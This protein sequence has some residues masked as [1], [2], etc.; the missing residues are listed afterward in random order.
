MSNKF[1]VFLLALSVL[2]SQSFSRG[3]NPPDEK[4]A[5]EKPDLSELIINPETIKVWVLR[6]DNHS[7]LLG[8]NA[9]QKSKL[10]Y[11]IAK[12]NLLPS[13]D[14]AALTSSV[15]NPSFLIPTVHAL[16]PFLVPSKWFDSASAK[17][18]FESDKFAFKTLQRDILAS[19]LSLYFSIVRDQD[20]LEQLRSD[21]SDLNNLERSIEARFEFGAARD[22]ELNLARS[23]R[24]L[25][26][27]RVVEIEQYL[28]AQIIE[29]KKAMSF[30]PRRPIILQN[31]QMPVD[32]NENMSGIELHNNSWQKSTSRQQIEQLRISAKNTKWSRVFAFFGGASISSSVIGDQK[33]PRFAAESLSA[34]ASFNLSFAQI[35]AIKLAGKNVEGI[36]LLLEEFMEESMYSTEKFALNLNRIIERDR[37]AAE[38]Q[39]LVLNNFRAQLE[40]YNLGAGATFQ[41]VLNARLGLQQSTL[42]KIESQR[43]LDLARVVLAR[44]LET[45]LFESF[46]DPKF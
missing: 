29:L 12:A 40:R 46:P 27:M 33:I 41:D 21:L 45:G 18:Q 19:A 38:A 16:L 2:S 14:F 11:S 20:L 34:G 5:E 17:Y 31:F 22:T 1:K 35:P 10:N 42:K 24:V 3:S 43:E 25:A 8:I 23:Q 15:T 13:L 30:D 36:D 26:Q 7:I 37:L 9:L 39:S 44:W 6:S 28:D 32:P 4:V